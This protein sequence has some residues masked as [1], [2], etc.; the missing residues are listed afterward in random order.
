MVFITPL[1]TLLSLSALSSFVSAATVQEPL[2]Q[3]PA[4]AAQ[5]RQA[6]KDMFLYSYDAY[7]SVLPCGAAVAEILTE[8]LQEVR[9]GSR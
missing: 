2:L 3:L 9:V 6:V 5:N 7:K 4:S 1:V 8:F